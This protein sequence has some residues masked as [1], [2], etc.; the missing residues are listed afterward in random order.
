MSQQEKRNSRFKCPRSN[1]YL[2]FLKHII[3]STL[4]VQILNLSSI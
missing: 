4:Q 2:F 3:K 1:T